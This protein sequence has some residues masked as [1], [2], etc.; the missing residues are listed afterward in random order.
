MNWLDDA[1]DAQPD[2][3]LLDFGFSNSKPGEGIASPVM[4]A[5]ILSAAARCLFIAASGNEGPQ[6]VSEPAIY[7]EILAVGAIDE[8]GEVRP[9]C[10]WLPDNNKPEVFMLDNLEGSELAAALDLG[11]IERLEGTSYAAF[12]ATAAAILVWS[13]IPELRPVDVRNLIMSAA[14]PINSDELSTDIVP[15]SVTLKQIVDAARMRLIE[16]MLKTGPCLAESLAA[17]AGL[18]TVYIRETL[19][20][21]RKEGRV[22]RTLSGRLERFEL[23]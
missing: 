1:L 2:I 11:D 12:H 23:G 7:P 6:I 22:I 5:T 4:R 10:A 3:V 18:D 19:E 20:T 17:I 15:K 21:M 9:Y 13:L 16:E 8:D 14:K